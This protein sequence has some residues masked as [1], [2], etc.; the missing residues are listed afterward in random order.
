[1]P[2]GS[3]KIRLT[4]LIGAVSLVVATLFMVTGTWG[5]DSDGA[6]PEPAPTSLPPTRETPTS[7]PS[8]RETTQS[9]STLPPEAAQPS[10]SDPISLTE[11]PTVLAVG[12]R[13]H[14]VGRTDRHLVHRSSDDRGATWSDPEVI[15]SGDGWPAQYGSMVAIGDTVYLL[16]VPDNPGPLPAK[17]ISFRK[18]TDGG[19]TWSSPVP[20]TSGEHQR[21]H[22]VS[23]AVSEDVVHVVGLR[24]SEEEGSD[25]AWYFRSTDSGE[26][27]DNGVQLDNKGGQGGIDIAV[28]GRAIHVAYTKINESSMAESK[29][30]TYYIR[31]IDNGE[32]FSEPTRIGGE[33]GIR[34]TRTR[35][36]VSDRVVI[37]S[38]SAD[39][40]Q[41]PLG[42][43]GS[44]KGVRSSDGGDTWTSI[45]TL[46]D[47]ADANNHHDMDMVGSV[48][49]LA[50][51]QDRDRPSPA[52]YRFSMDDGASWSDVETAFAITG[53]EMQVWNLRADENWV[54]L[55]GFV[56]DTGSTLYV[57]RPAS[58]PN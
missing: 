26:T 31:S 16:T 23:I 5:P 7:P 17:D 55:S 48:I 47:T 44:I 18:S 15:G 51:G 54:H 29:F 49:H 52:E 50:W 36:D 25:E 22:R 9:S 12:D 1:M 32:T 56:I 57:R 58:P 42:W 3:A 45:E 24:S 37:V 21:V 30:E 38:W 39:S 8:V 34:E 10:W 33:A 11:S 28:E 35:I 43:G 53:S 20:V 19:A 27:W 13:V 46:A 14:A 6:L 4:L 41:D 2:G 40:E